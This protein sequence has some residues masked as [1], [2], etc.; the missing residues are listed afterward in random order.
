[1]MKEQNDHVDLVDSDE[2]A[3]VQVRPTVSSRG[4]VRVPAFA[5]STTDPHD[6]RAPEFMRARRS[7]GASSSRET[8]KAAPATRPHVPTKDAPSTDRTEPSPPPPPTAAKTTTAPSSTPRASEEVGRAAPSS[9]TTDAGDKA[10]TGGPQ[11]APAT[12]PPVPLEAASDGAAVALAA[13]DTHAFERLNDAVLMLRHASTSLAEQ[14]R[15]DAL[16]IGIEIARQIVRQELSTNVEPLIRLVKDAIR[17]AGDARVIRVR[18][19]ADD[20]RRLSAHAGELSTSAISA[21]H[22]EIVEDDSL[23]RGDVEIDTDFGRI[24][25]RMS[26]RLDELKR[27]VED[28]WQRPRTRAGET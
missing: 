15:S 28:G 11:A 22:V 26:R 5:Q 16:E 27:A 7:G 4:S 25:G 13:A 20:A 17:Q 6:V 12:A 19:A 1:M 9:S 8:A 18:L 14:A 10:R 24:D 21:A 3:R 23:S 2:R